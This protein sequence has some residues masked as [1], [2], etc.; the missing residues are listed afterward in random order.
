MVPLP[1]QDD[2]TEQ[3]IQKVLDQTCSLIPVDY[4][5]CQQFINT[6][7]DKLIVL[8]RQDVTAETICKTLRLCGTRVAVPEKNLQKNCGL[9]STVVDYII[10][11]I[12]VSIT[13]E[14]STACTAL[15]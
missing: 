12:S 13:K 4:G 11:K 3:N 10:D 1:E 8:L 7:I 5:S 2:R 14:P 9:C 15:H 6:N